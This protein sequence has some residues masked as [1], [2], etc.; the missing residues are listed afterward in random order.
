M[1]RGAESG[2][3]KIAWQGMGPATKPS[4]VSYTVERG[5]LPMKAVL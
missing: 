3:S 2:A 4:D 1:H 5:N